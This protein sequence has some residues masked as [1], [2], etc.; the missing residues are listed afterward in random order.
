MYLVLSHPIAV[1][2]P[3]TDYNLIWVSFKCHSKLEFPFSGSPKYHSQ[4]SPNGTQEEG[5]GLLESHSVLLS[6]LQ[7]SLPI[8]VFLQKEQPVSLPNTVLGSVLSLWLPQPHSLLLTFSQGEWGPQIFESSRRFI[9]SF[10][11]LQG[12]FF[13]QFK[14]LRMELF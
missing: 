1:L 11:P 5:K 7:L 8:S 13:F 10:A 2:I 3:P 6:F 12:N 9:L 4:W 14:T